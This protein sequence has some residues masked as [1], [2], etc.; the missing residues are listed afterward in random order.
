MNQVTLSPGGKTESKWTWA[1]M[2]GSTEC[3]GPTG[4]QMTTKPNGTKTVSQSRGA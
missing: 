1:M 4:E 2:E 3:S